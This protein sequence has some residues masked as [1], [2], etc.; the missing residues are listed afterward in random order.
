MAGIYIHIPFCK[1]RCI[2][3][4][5]YSTTQGNKSDEYI[6]SLCKE[7]VIRKDYLNNESIE[8]IYWGGGTPSQLNEY[9][10]E[11][12][13]NTI[14]ANYNIVD[15]AEITIECNPD[16]LK[17]SYVS[18]LKEF[19]FNRLSMGVQ[20]FDDRTLQFLKRRHNSLQAVKAF[21]I[22]RDA[23]FRNISLDLMYGLIGENLSKWEYDLSKIIK[24]NPEHI[25]AYH[26]IYEEGTELWNLRQKHIVDEINEDLSLQ[27]FTILIDKLCSAGYEH[28]E[29]SNFAK[30]GLFSRHNTS[31]WMNKKYM[32]CGPSAHSF[33]L[34]SRQWNVASLEKYID[35]VNNGQ[36]FY[37][38]EKLDNYTRYNDF[39]ITA[40]R[41]KWGLNL[42]ELK[43]RF[44]EEL[45]LFSKKMAGQYLKSG[46]LDEKDGVIKLTKKGIFISDSIMSDMLWV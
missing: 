22:C 40:L 32:G 3:C 23:G 41:T 1:T 2:Y 42:S 28:Y 27:M 21:N 9:H 45:Y 20:T 29:I 7:L 13:F 31:Y 44:G 35:T 38:I 43:E 12:V 24:L 17:E 25:S 4:D 11:K 36:C 37:E 10:F 8:T 39:V 19:P 46:V 5:F 15:N 16:D 33:N 34:E 6:S 18:T 26:L 14:Y 30:P